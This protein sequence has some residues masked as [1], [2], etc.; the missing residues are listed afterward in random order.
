MTSKGLFLVILV[1]LAAATLPCCTTLQSTA[2]TMPDGTKRLDQKLMVTAGGKL[3]D[4]IM[5]MSAKAAGSD[6]STWSVKSGTG[7]AKADTPDSGSQIL[8][9][10]KVGMQLQNTIANPAPPKPDKLQAALDYLKTLG[11]TAVPAK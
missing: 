6:G 2:Y 5:D 10:V 9:A 4:G 7:A 11:M 8:E 1:L 3:T